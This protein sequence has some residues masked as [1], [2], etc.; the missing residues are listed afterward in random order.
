MEHGPFEDVFPIRNGDIPASYVSLPEGTF[1][2]QTVIYLVAQS[3][4]SQ[5]KQR[6]KRVQKRF[7][8]NAPH[9]QIC[10]VLHEQWKKPG[11]LG[12]FRDYT[13]QLYRG[14]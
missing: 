12:Y 1:Y 10:Q 5:K 2:L 14:S 6:C 4:E 9:L 3:S 11:C 7:L 13:T 8:E